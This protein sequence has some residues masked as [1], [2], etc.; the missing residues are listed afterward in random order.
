MP[1]F[2]VD[3]QDGTQFYEDDIGSELVSL[4]QARLQAVSLLTQ[5]SKDKIQGEDFRQFTAIVLDSARIPLYK[6]TLTYKGEQIA[7]PT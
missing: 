6:A 1:R 5:L 3:L 4:E 7:P 2:Y